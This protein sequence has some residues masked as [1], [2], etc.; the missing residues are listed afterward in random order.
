MTL[1]SK[2]AIANAKYGVQVT[3]VESNHFLGLDD[4]DSLR[5]ADRQDIKETDLKKGGSLEQRFE[6]ALPSLLGLMAAAFVA[7]FL[8]ALAGDALGSGKREARPPGAKPA[9]VACAPR[10]PTHRQPGDVDG[11][12]EPDDGVVRG[13]FDAQLTRRG[14]PRSGP[15]TGA[16]AG[17]EMNRPES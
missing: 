7:R 14:A 6:P 15:Q 5:L 3:G 16:F 1:S 10:A 9:H 2:L 13:R 11:P 17:T 8:N 4:A 12:L